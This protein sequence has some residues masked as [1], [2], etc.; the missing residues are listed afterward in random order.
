MNNRK[1]KLSSPSRE[2][3]K[4]NGGRRICVVASHASVKARNILLRWL[5]SAASV[6]RFLYCSAH[7]PCIIAA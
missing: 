3:E 5:F 2:K 7:Y 1:R 6:D 4:K